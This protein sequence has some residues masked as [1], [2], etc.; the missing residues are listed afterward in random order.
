MPSEHSYCISRSDTQWALSTDVGTD[1]SLARLVIT[2][3]NK[4]Y[5]YRPHQSISHPKLGQPPLP[6]TL[7]QG[8]FY[9]HRKWGEQGLN[10]HTMQGLLWS[11]PRAL[12]AHSCVCPQLGCLPPSLPW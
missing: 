2:E 9:I 1:D 8:I 5:V 7:L 11:A 4:A 10:T 6:H 12:S 3:M